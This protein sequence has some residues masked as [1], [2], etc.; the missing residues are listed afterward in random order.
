MQHSQVAPNLSFFALFE[1]L[2]MPIQKQQKAYIHH[3]F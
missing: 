1:E 2:F 3:K